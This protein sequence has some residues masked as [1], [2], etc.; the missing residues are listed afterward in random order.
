MGELPFHISKFPEALKYHVREPIKRPKLLRSDLPDP[1]EA[2]ILKAVA[3]RVDDRFATA[4]E[5]ARAI[6]RVGADVLQEGPPPKFQGTVGLVTEWQ[7]SLIG[8]FDPLPTP[9]NL[10]HGSFS[11]PFLQIRTPDGQHESFPIKRK[12]LTI[13]RNDNCDLVLDDT[14]VSREH[15]EIRQQGDRF[16]ITDLGS[17]N[18]T[19]LNNERLQ[20]QQPTPLS[21]VDALRIGNHAL[22]LFDN[23][24]EHV[25]SEKSFQVSVGQNVVQG[26]KGHAVEIPLHVTNDSQNAVRLDVTMM[27]GDHRWLQDIRPFDIG[28]G[29][30][31]DIAVTLNLPLDHLDKNEYALTF[32]VRGY[33]RE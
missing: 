10:Y 6:E 25:E 18:G 14:Q 31:K 30:K 1:V 29:Q 26:E 17:T 2:L 7:Q 28:A 5:F 24:R 13:G 8:R 33:D 9:G 20:S 12:R 32:R 4:A 23:G 15:A 19:F 3:K 21:T 16:S 22:R 11:G 27:G